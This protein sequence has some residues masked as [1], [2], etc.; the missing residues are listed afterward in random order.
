MANAWQIFIVRYLLIGIIGTATI[1]LGTSLLKAAAAQR[2]SHVADALLCSK[3]VQDTLARFIFRNL[4]T[5]RRRHRNEGREIV[6]ERH[7]VR[8]SDTGDRH[9]SVLPGKDNP[10][11]REYAAVRTEY[12][13]FR[14]KAR[15][16]RAMRDSA[17]GDA[18][19]RHIDKLRLMKAQDIALR[20]A[21]ETAERKYE[22]WNGAHTSKLQQPRHE[23]RF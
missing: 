15:Q 12:E 18:R 6:I 20:S 23:E 19:M 22:F 13:G 16:L 5:R 11:A 1:V 2:D 4:E 9:G 10:Y 8:Q 7:P 14:K 17:T 3:R 21:L